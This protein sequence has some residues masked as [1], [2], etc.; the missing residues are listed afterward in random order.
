MGFADDETAIIN[1]LNSNKHLLSLRGINEAAKLKTNFLNARCAGQGA[2]YWHKSDIISVY[3]TLKDLRK[4]IEKL[5]S[6]LE[7]S[8]RKDI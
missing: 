6:K 8:K 1:F 5:E 2:A 3:W 7:V 4:Q